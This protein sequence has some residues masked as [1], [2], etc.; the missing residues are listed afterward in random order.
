MT[1]PAAPTFLAPV[2][3]SEA[4]D[5][6]LAY[7]EAEGLTLYPAQEEA[8]LALA[9]GKHVILNTPTGSGKSLVA[10]FLQYL[11]LC[12][13]ERSV[14]TCPIKA[15]V[16][17]KFLQLC[18]IF[19]AERVGLSTGD[20]SVNQGAEILV[21]TAEVLSEIALAG[22]GTRGEASFVGGV[23]MDEFHYYSDPERG[24]AWQVPLLILP[25][26]QF[27]LMS[28]TLGDLEFIAKDL[29]KKT[30]WPVEIIVGVER[31]VP[32]EYEYSDKSILR[33]LE[34]LVAAGKAPVYV[35]HFSQRESVEFAE[36]L[37]SQ[38][39][40]T[41]DEKSKLKEATPGERF[42]SP[43]GDRLKRLL[44]HGIGLHHAGILPK[45]R[46][47]VEQLAQRGLLKVICGT[48]TLG[49]G[50]NVPIRTVLFSGLNKYDGRKVGMLTVRDFQQV[51]GRAGR[52]GFDTIGTV[53]VQAPEHIVEN[54]EIDEKIK[55]DPGKAKKL[56]K[57]K[58]PEKGYAAWEA[59]TMERLRTAKAEPLQSRFRVG[60]GMVLHL[61]ARPRGHRLLR[62]LIRG[63]H[64]SD[65][66]KK[67]WRRTAF[68]MVRSL[69]DRG[70]LKWDAD[71][72]RPSIELPREFSLHQTLSLFL[73]DLLPKLP[74][75]GDPYEMELLSA[76][77][78]VVENPEV[79]LRA[80]LSQAKGRLVQQ[81]KAEGM[82]YDDRM[83]ALEKVE[84]PKPLKEKLYQAHDEFAALHPWME[85]DSVKPKSIVR[86]MIEQ[87]ATF[88]EYV[89]EYE[90]ER[91]EGVLLRYLMEVYKVLNQTLPD[92]AKTEEV[93]LITEFVRVQIRGTDSSL[94]EEWARL[95]DGLPPGT[96]VSVGVLDERP[97]LPPKMMIERR[98][99]D[100][101]IALRNAVVLAMRAIGNG[102][103]ARAVDGFRDPVLTA[104]ALEAAAKV[105]F[106]EFGTLST[107]PKARDPKWL[108][109]R[110]VEGDDNA[111]AF[112]QVLF[113]REG[114]TSWVIEGVVSF[115]AD[116]AEIE[117]FRAI[118][119]GEASGAESE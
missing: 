79:I 70:I 42:T 88:A 48:D 34:N 81:L 100:R 23:I 30:R 25:E 106:A 109:V 1:N 74:L 117:G 11:S 33:K 10:L 22:E 110:A 50:I 78:S 41:A 107:D 49:V 111:L 31:P 39:F 19:G 27:L 98:R 12:R 6:F 84:Y 56:V 47:L 76:V 15:L 67:K 8:L 59:S 71:G 13:G 64:E 62:D 119:F 65:F 95:R 75:A 38:D 105:Y 35:V 29:E 14:Y 112:T 114:D 77:E 87:Y 58:P 5:R 72:I 36:Q 44:R 3:K 86:E 66:L 7:V 60:Y 20:A 52:R 82:E 9:E 102:Q 101:V 53:V 108:T 43:F 85:I 115:R 80:Q 16:N 113:S 21:C 94:L 92:E 51:A 37:L 89:R 103:F 61:L 28:A 18:Q 40:C 2:P 90:L 91:S 73:I 24:V 63:S 55:K 69:L 68:Q 26:T 57:R 83:E 118:R 116:S 4:F 96:A 97:E 93:D 54:L 45:Y 46:I 32:L 99:R 104:P 17:E